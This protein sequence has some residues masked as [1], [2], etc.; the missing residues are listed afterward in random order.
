[1][2]GLNKATLIG[3][4]GEKPEVKTLESGIKVASFSV[5]TNETYKDSEGNSKTETEWHSIVAWSNLATVVEK[6]FEK[7]TKVYLEGKIKTRNYVDKL[8]QTKYVTEI[9]ADNVIML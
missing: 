9:I 2:K 5:A 6:Y 7:G 8:G 1:M 3:N 4:L